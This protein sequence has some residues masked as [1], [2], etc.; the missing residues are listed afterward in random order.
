MTHCLS[1]ELSSAL[2][3]CLLNLTSIAGDICPHQ[4][5]LQQMFYMLIDEQISPN[6]LEHRVLCV[7]QFHY[8][9]SPFNLRRFE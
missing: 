6:L 1:L 7:F 2:R 9:N 3:K 4:Q 8:L 5:E